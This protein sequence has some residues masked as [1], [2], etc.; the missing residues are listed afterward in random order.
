MGEKK[1]NN[2][3][4]NNTHSAPLLVINSPVKGEFRLEFQFKTRATDI[5]ICQNIAWIAIG[6]AGTFSRLQRVLPRTWFV[7]ELP[8]STGK[9][10]YH[11]D[12]KMPSVENAK[13]RGT[14]T[15]TKTGCVT[16]ELP[17]A[18]TDPE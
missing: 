7:V 13:F 18:A 14:A 9:Y 4:N 11:A 5:D 10:I 1:T 6:A 3:N 12:L 15:M 16:L 2:N 8:L 17:Q